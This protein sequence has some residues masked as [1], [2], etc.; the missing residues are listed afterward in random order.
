MDKKK[1]EIYRPTAPPKFH[2]FLAPILQEE[3]KPKSFADH[4]TFKI[5]DLNASLETNRFS[6]ITSQVNHHVVQT[7]SKDED[8]IYVDKMTCGKFQ[9]KYHIIDSKHIDSIDGVI[10]VIVE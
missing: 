6:F 1:I 8:M 4:S 9:I 3:L 2:S 10:N 7:L 5:W